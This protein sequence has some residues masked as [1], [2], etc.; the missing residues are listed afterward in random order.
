MPMQAP[1]PCT[2]PGC[3][4]RVTGG[5][6][7]DKHKQDQWRTQRTQGKST[8]ER[9]YGH[10]WQQLRARVMRR[11]QEMCVP[12]RKRGFMVRAHAVDHI[13]PKANGGTDDMDNL[14]A[15]C[16]TCHRVKTRSESGV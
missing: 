9:G 6:R 1:R 2:Y 12:C 3:H 15:I 13:K 10:D 14:Q 7:C 16:N 8:S 5:S 11:D 4:A